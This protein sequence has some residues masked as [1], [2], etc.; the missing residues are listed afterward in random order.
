MSHIYDIIYH[1]LG[2]VNC[3]NLIIVLQTTVTTRKD[4]ALSNP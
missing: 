2:I 4:S 3:Y 1:K